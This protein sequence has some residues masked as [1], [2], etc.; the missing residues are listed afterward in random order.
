MTFNLV[1]GSATTASEVR[2]SLNAPHAGNTALRKSVLLRMQDATHLFR[3]GGSHEDMSGSTHSVA[4]S[5]MVWPR[6]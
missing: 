4:A 6:I 3:S 5:E 2:L 1:A